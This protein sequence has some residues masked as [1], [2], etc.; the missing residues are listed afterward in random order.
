MVVIDA[1][2]VNWCFLNQHMIITSQQCDL[3]SWNLKLYFDR[4]VFSYFSTASVAE[5]I[6]CD[7]HIF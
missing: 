7:G 2:L 3:R 4:T 6:M 1:Y 5:C